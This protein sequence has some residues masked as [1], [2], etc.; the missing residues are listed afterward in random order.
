[1]APRVRREVGEVWGERKRN[2]GRT[3]KRGREGGRVN[4]EGIKAQGAPLPPQT[5][6]G[7]VERYTVGE[8]EGERESP[9][10]PG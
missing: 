9:S 2:G 8:R 5:T 1:M 7:E 4:G 6:P 10:S 3:G